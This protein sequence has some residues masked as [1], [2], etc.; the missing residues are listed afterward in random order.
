MSELWEENHEQ[1]PWYFMADFDDKCEGK[2][3]YNGHVHDPLYAN[4]EQET[5]PVFF[6]IEKLVNK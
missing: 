6:W 1:C 2:V 4:C 3:S 5:C